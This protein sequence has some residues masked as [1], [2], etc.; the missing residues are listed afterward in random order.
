MNT[1]RMCAKAE[2]GFNISVKLVRYGKRHYAHHACYLDA[3]KKLEELHAWQVGEFPFRLL[4]V[5]GLLDKAEQIVANDI[6]KRVVLLRE[7]GR[8][9]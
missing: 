5:R 2:F 9:P 4:Q 1:C 3:G 6:E 8:R 7:E